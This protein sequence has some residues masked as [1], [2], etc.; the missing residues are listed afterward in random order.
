VHPSGTQA[1]QRG[2]RGARITGWPRCCCSGA[3]HRPLARSSQRRR[4]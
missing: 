2:R 3:A 1:L 4:A